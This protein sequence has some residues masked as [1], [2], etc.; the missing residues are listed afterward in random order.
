MELPF[1]LALALRYLIPHRVFLSVITILSILG[2][3]V[4]VMCLVVVIPVMSGFEASVKERLLGS[5]PHALLK[6]VRHAQPQV[7]GGP[8][9]E[10]AGLPI[11]DWQE[12]VA[13][14][15]ALPQVESAFPVI[16]GFVMLEYDHRRSPEPMFAVDPEDNTLAP[17][18]AANLDL[19]RWPGGSADLSQLP[20]NSEA[21]GVCLLN[22]VSA[23]NLGIRPGDLITLYSPST[24]ERILESLTDL[25]RPPLANRAGE[26]LLQLERDLVT[27]LQP[28]ALEAG[29]PAPPAGTALG[30]AEALSLPFDLGQRIYQALDDLRSPDNRQSENAQIDDLIDKLNSQLRVEEETGRVI[31]AASRASSPLADLR[32]GLH[33]LG[34]PPTQQEDDEA[35]RQLKRVILP[36]SLEVIGVFR[37]YGN[38]ASV[39]VPLHIGQELYSLDDEVHAI[40][41]RTVDGYHVDRDEALWQPI[42]DREW[43]SREL[44]ISWAADT[45]LERWGSLFGQIRNERKIMYIILFFIV[46]VACFSICNTLVTTTVLKRREVGLLKAFGATSGQINLIFLLQGAI[47]GLLGTLSGLGA[48]LLLLQLRNPLRETIR[49]TTGYDLFPSDVYGLDGGI[50]AL[51]RPED[52]I[53]ICVGAFA[54]ACLAALPPAMIISRLQ[55]APALRAQGA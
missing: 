37:G 3:V 31:Y 33:D 52:M 7:P 18:L 38:S 25:E 43:G 39:I 29:G 10:Q 27:A 20:G 32:D 42:L 45:W 21:D 48:G 2:I 40:G 34:T 15:R 8:L 54:L 19:E 12:R 26:Q 46:I 47:V 13:R 23:E 1:S 16:E 41:V 6:Q 36:K 49:A 28:A 30:D 17:E 50:P 9:S 4:A 14:A 24:F 22:S 53:T 35:L 5:Q 44:G 51:I 11:A 55:P